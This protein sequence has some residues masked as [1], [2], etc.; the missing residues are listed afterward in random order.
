[1]TDCSTNPT[2]TRKDQL[3][4]NLTRAALAAAAILTAAGCSHLPIPGL[5]AASTTGVTDGPYALI[6]EPQAG[7]ST[8]S[9]RID[10][11]K[12][13]VRVVIYELADDVIERSLENAK[14]RGVDVKVL[15]DFAFH[16][17]QANQRAYTRLHAAGVDVR[18][19]PTGTI[20]HQKTVVIDDDTAII[21][22]ANFD[23][24][25]YP[26]GRDAMIVSAVPE[27]VSAIGAT[28]DGDY[29]A[30]DSGRLSQA[31]DAPGLIWS[32]AARAEYIRTINA[33][34]GVLDVTSEELK[35]HAAAISLSE[36]ARRGVPCKILLNADDAGTP[37]VAQVKEAGCAVRV[38]P[39]STK[40][41]YM[42]EKIVV[43]DDSVI[44]G[45]Q[46]LSTK[47]L[48][49][50]RELSIRLGKAAAPNIAAAVQKQFDEDFD[51]ATP[52]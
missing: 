5:T 20:V 47:S 21:S 34:R 19:A 37:A 51:K 49:E 24:K 16:G 26:T 33:A 39:T 1:M 25:Y 13:S 23:A 14:N 41:L 35:D 8:I 48:T 36:A 12:K 11:A 6:Q 52:A 7:Y 3:L 15:L 38:L 18:W 31:V 32:P 4:Q 9:S 17:Q 40:G 28:F 30:V 50:N 2:I 27:Q 44:I 22:T 10:G 45:S 42:H 43:T 29:G 46:N